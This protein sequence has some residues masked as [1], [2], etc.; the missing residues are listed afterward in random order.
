MSKNSKKLNFKVDLIA[1]DVCDYDPKTKTNNYLYE[2]GQIFLHY[3]FNVKPK[4]LY[5]KLKPIL[6]QQKH[7]IGLMFIE[8]GHNLT[9][10]KLY[11]VNNVT[12]LNPNLPL[13]IK[14]NITFTNDYNLP[15]KQYLKQYFE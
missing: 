12:K 8:I 11:P 10:A 1:Y 5:S 6:K 14:Q 4:H 9:T 15:I 7:N 13:P 3:E 2:A